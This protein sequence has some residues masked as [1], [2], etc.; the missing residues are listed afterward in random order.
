MSL[1]FVDMLDEYKA[2]TKF[3]RINRP[4]KTRYYV[5]QLFLFLLISFEWSVRLILNIFNIVVY[6]PLLSHHVKKLQDALTK[7]FLSVMRKIDSENTYP[8][9]LP[10]MKFQ[11]NNPTPNDT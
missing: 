3:V 7:V 11:A 8:E 2:N 10:P 5:I 9:H 4:S 1:Y 6:R